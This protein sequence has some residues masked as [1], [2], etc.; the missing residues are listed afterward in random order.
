MGNKK[1]PLL[2]EILGFTLIILTLTLALE[3]LVGV[4]MDSS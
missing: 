1:C 4:C 2:G 3:Y